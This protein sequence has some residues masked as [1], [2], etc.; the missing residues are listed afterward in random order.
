MYLVALAKSLLFILLEAATVFVCS[1]YGKEKVIIKGIRKCLSM[2][3]K[4]V[5]RG[6]ECKSRI[7]S[8]NLAVILSFVDYSKIPMSYHVLSFYCIH[9]FG[10]RAACL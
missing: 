7:V 5:L 2:F 8:S 3:E 9:N 4:M 1:V 6:Q 10:S